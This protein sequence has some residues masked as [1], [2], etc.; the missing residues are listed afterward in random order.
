[1]Q[2]TYSG[3]GSVY[4]NYTNAAVRV[5]ELTLDPQSAIYVDA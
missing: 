5:G 4:V 1:M 3:G 2:I